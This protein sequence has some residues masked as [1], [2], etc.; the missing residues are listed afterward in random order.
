MIT[1][2]YDALLF[3]T[4]GAGESDGGHQTLANLEPRDVLGAY[5]FMKGRGYRP[6][7]LTVFGTSMGGAAT[8]E[9]APGLADVGAIIADSSFADLG[10]ILAQQWSQTTLLP[11]S[12]DIVGVSIARL[13]DVNPDLRPAAVVRSLRNRAFLLFHAQ[14][15]DLI[16]VAQAHELANASA[17]PGTVLYI[18]SGAAHQ[19][20]F[21]IDPTLYMERVYSFIDSQL[22]IGNTAPTDPGRSRSL[23]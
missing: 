5:D 21:V 15:D 17:N 4:R 19:Q 14:G 11:G 9:A 1:K 10:P 6:H 12:S 22:G 13:F 20:T 18:T 23:P 16:P 8:I 7:A 2:G 3:E